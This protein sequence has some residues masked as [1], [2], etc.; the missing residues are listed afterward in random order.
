MQQLLELLENFE[1]NALCLSKGN[2]GEKM[3]NLPIVRFNS[4]TT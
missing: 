1:R 3:S 2:L 4:D